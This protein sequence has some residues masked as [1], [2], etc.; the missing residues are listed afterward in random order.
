MRIDEPTGILRGTAAEA[1]G[2]RPAGGPA[3]LPGLRPGD[4]PAGAVRRPDGIRAHRPGDGRGGPLSAADTHGRRT[5]RD[6]LPPPLPRKAH[7]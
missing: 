3:G 4:G 6:P 1:V 7:A 5:V 2:P